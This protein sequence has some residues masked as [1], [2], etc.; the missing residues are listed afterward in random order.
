MP[1][2][3]SSSDATF[4]L[5]ADGHV[6]SAS[7]AALTLLGAAPDAITA[8]ASAERTQELVRRIVA[9]ESTGGS[10]QMLGSDGRPLWMSLEAGEAGR[11]A[12]RLYVD[13]RTRAAEGSTEGEADRLRLLA[14]VMAQGGRDFA[15][16]VREVLALTTTLL[17]LDVGILSQIEGE[18]YHVAACHAPGADLE[19]GAVFALGDTYCSI[20]ITGRDI[21]EIPHI[22]ASPHRAHPCHA[23]FG[24]ESYVGAPVVVGDEVWGT[25]SFSAA[26]PLSRPLTAAERSMI[27][28]LGIW[29]GGVI[30]RDERAQALADAG[31]QLKAVVR[32]APV[33]LYALDADGQFTL[34][35]GRGLG[36]LGVDDGG[37]VGANVFEA[38]ADVPA[39]VNNLRRVLAGEERTWQADVGPLTF[40]SWAAPL[41]GAEGEVVGATGVSFDVTDRRQAEA[42]A[43]A[44]LERF[45]ALAASAV[46]AVI[47]TDAAGLVT[48]WN[49]AAEHTFGYAAGDMLG[50]PFARILPAEHHDAIQVGMDGVLETGAHQF[51]DGTL[52]LDLVR[53]SGESFP[54]DVSFSSWGE[55]ED[56][57]FAAILR[58][59][60]EA[61]AQQDS[62][63]ES[64]ERFRALSEASFEAIVFTEAG[65]ITDCN[66]Q[67][68]RLFGYDGVEDVVGRHALDFCAPAFREV[69]GRMISENREGTYEAIV[70]HKDGTPFWAEIQGR[71]AT[72]DGRPT[73]LTA[74]RDVTARKEA[75]E[76]RR[77]QADVL[78]HVSDAVVALDLEGRIT[79]WNVGAEAL[80]GRRAEDVLGRPLEDVVTYR[81]PDAASHGGPADAEDALRSA[82]AR[83]GELVYVAPSGARRFVSVSSSVLRDEAGEER[84]I[85]A[86]SRD[87]TDRREM[88]ARLRH[89]ASHDVLT[90]LPN[91]AL[92]RERIE[93]ALAEGEPFGVLFV[94]LDRFKVVNDSLGHDAGDTLLTTV[95]SR[96]RTALGAVEDA[97][98]ARLG[99]DE[100][101]VIVPTE[102]AVLL[103]VADVVL[104]AVG[105]PIDLGARAITPGASVGVVDEGE[106]YDTPEDLLRDADTAMYAS[107]RG[108]RGRATLFDHSMHEAAALRFGMEHDLR[109]AIERDQ[110]S[111]HYQPIV[112][113]AT[114]AVAGF[115]SLVRWEHPER[116]LLPPGAF[117][118]LAEEL[119]LVAD[120]DRWVL[121]E[122]CRETATWAE[123]L[124]DGVSFVSVNCSDQAFLTDG[125][126]D[127]ARDAI[128]SSG[129]PPD[130]FY[131]E[132]TERALV[133][134]H[135]ASDVLQALRKHGIRLCLD[136]F[137]TGYS[138]LGLLHRLP[139]DGLK[140]DRSFVWDLD[141]D[142]AAG[143][144]VRSVVQLAADLGIQSVAEGV[145]TPSQLRALRAA[146]TPLAQGY[147]FARPMPPAEAR[148][149]I[150]NPPWADDWALWTAG[151]RLGR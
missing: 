58:D 124:N 64:E 144:V 45:E 24:I 122:S 135:R 60:S 53:A 103:D 132:L 83:D 11:I 123:W 5:D 101:G 84:G 48:S 63:Q 44:N 14:T 82:A 143:P 109:L 18:D 88:S 37:L 145:E 6:V 39:A 79:Y 30:E 62:L 136:D 71:S 35:T 146:G 15:D 13:R 3:P 105:T 2:V 142:G 1:D 17:G 36:V 19:A 149:A 66:G 87:V 34:S 98:V 29:V 115:E 89:Q 25:L 97:L 114:G 140:I 139:V 119:G 111:I 121:V 41:Y 57:E 73:R 47:T 131:L 129:L 56:A 133:D 77:F 9:G 72:V 126:A 32:T 113:L 148:A 20:T 94:D 117:I 116:G 50:Q 125:L 137:G 107:K 150:A 118:P 8:S 130:R 12:G 46:D 65:T 75:E 7:D 104:A 81:L 74:L 76:Q 59:V 40:D 92:F 28:L 95:S 106:Q 68:A 134:P 38:Y 147:L 4:E 86:V 22:S 90:G 23:A 52:R 70:L 141:G 102:S 128:D 16:H 100:F 54:A 21:L 110:L 61:V 31:R 96:L 33:I 112:D 99:G 43:R 27:R 55:G 67:F 93:A 85:L 91:R 138:S 127:W 151:A 10:L 78:A 42:A 26:T 51:F 80:H 69:A 49:L 120:I 108:G